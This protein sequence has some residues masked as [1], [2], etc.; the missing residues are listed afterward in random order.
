MPSLS[1]T[2]SPDGSRSTYSDFMASPHPLKL[3]SIDLHQPAD[4]EPG[5]LADLLGTPEGRRFQGITVQNEDLTGTS[6]IDSVLENMGL[7]DSDLSAVS[8]LTSWLRGLNAPHLQAPRSAWRQVMVEGSRIGAAELYEAVFDTVMLRGCKLDLVNL[9]GAR[10]TDVVLDS[11][12]IGE[13]DLTAASVRRLQLRSCDVDVLILSQAS[14]AHADLRGC[15]L[16]QLVGLDSLRGA[17]ISPEQLTDLAPSFAEQLG[18]SVLA[19]D[20]GA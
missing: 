8:V 9:R 20:G 1:F 13:L 7:V 19:P 4:L 12:T 5:T 16:R 15:R 6:I 18:L 2:V 3:P 14:L 17:V 10:L 11:C